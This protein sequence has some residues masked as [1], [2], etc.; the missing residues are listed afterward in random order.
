MS[1]LK[2]RCFATEDFYPMINATAFEMDA[3]VQYFYGRLNVV[4]IHMLGEHIKL[5]PISDKNYA[6]LRTAIGET[7]SK[8]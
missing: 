8:C 5:I 6:A 2:F 1:G 4:S 7:L 3:D